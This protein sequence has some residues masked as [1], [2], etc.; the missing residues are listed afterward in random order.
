MER[1][2][3]WTV[4]LFAVTAA[5]AGLSGKTWG[6]SMN[7]ALGGWLLLSA[8]LVPRARIATFWTEL[9]V[10]FGLVFLAMLPSLTAARHRRSNI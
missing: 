1:V 8:L 6:R 2:T 9:V 5:L 10:G 7:A 4:G 3:G